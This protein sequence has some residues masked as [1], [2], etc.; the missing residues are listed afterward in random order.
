[1]TA[2]NIAAT[3]AAGLAL[4]ELD[5]MRAMQRLPEPQA[6]LQRLEARTA[7]FNLLTGVCAAY[8][9]AQGVAE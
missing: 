6:L 3:V 9:K 8:L 7:D 4:E 2:A 1:M 5:R